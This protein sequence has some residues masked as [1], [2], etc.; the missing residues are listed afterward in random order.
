MNQ[1]NP[2][3]QDAQHNHQT[4]VSTAPSGRLSAMTMAILGAILLAVLLAGVAIGFGISKNTD[5][6]D[7]TK[8]AD[9]TDKADKHTTPVAMTVEAVHPAMAET[10]QSITANGNIAAKHIAQVSGRITGATIEQVLVEV[11]D[12]VRAGQVLAVLDAS[13]LRDNDIQARAD[14]EQAIASA[15]KA[16]ADLARTEPLLD[17]DAISRQ[18]VDAYRTAAKQA[19]ATV[20]AARAKANSAATSLNNAKI[21]APVSG[22]VSDRQAQVGVLVSGNPL[23]TII[24]DGVLEWRATLS[25][26]D[27]AKISIGQT[28]VIGTQDVTITGKVTRLSPTANSGREITVHVSL[29]PDAPLSEGMYQTGKFILSHSHAPAVPK[30]AVMTSDGHDYVWTLTP[31]AGDIAG[32]TGLYQVAR[33]KMTILSY[34]GDKVITDLSPQVLVVARSAGF[35][36]END[37]VRAVMMNE[38]SQPSKQGE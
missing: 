21:V 20:V 32:Q 17:I 23:F 13:S 2:A 11:G 4:A 37:V 38:H 6:T 35:L 3:N 28:A 33:T 26:D 18:Q 12:V 16:H 9:K 31:K 19:D 27:A 8:Q 14:L 24:K 15:E 34:E 30:S 22:I 29:P 36:S 1:D 5:G 7:N 25:P 10:T